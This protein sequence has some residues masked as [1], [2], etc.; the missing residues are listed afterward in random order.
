MERVGRTFNICVVGALLCQV[1]LTFASENSSE[2]IKLDINDDFFDGDR[3]SN[4]NDSV[5][6]TESTI[7]KIKK[8]TPKR[9]SDAPGSNVQSE[10]AA[11]N[12][13]NDQLASLLRLY[14]IE[15]L[16]KAWSYGNINLSDGCREHM[17]LFLRALN[18]FEL[19]ALKEKLSENI[20]LRDS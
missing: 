10:T 15:L 14:D 19:W 6:F 13:S 20:L 17:G 2:L 5:V 4:K 12:G 18:K 11:Q 8:N 7:F 16:E 9:G 3:Y 1:I